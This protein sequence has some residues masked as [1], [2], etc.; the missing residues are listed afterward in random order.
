MKQILSVSVQNLVGFVLRSGDLAGGAFIS[1]RM[2]DGVRG[3]RELQALRSSEHEAA[4]GPGEEPSATY[5]AEVPLSAR[6]EY[7]YFTLEVTGRADGV[8]TGPD[9]S[10]T[11]EEIKTVS[12]NPAEIEGEGN[13]LHWAQAMC[14]AAML[15]QNGE[16]PEITIRLTYYGRG[17]RGVRSFHRTHGADELSRFFADLSDRY[18][19]WAELL[20]LRSAER[21]ASIAALGFPF[22]TYRPGQRSFAARVY[23]TVRDGKRLFA[24]APTGIGKTAAALF[25]ALKAL[26][27]GLTARI[28]YLTAKT[29]TAA[30]VE[31]TLSLLRERGLFLTSVTLTA[32]EKLCP[33]RHD[34]DPD[35]GRTR[36]PCA[37]GL[38]RL[39]EG[40]YDRLEPAMRELM[41]E[42]T[43]FSRETILRYAERHSLCPFEFSLDVALWCDLVVCDYNYLFDP[44]ASLKR[45]FLDRGGEYTF[46]IDEAH[47]L[48]E[49]AREMFSAELEKRNVLELKRLAA[50]E[51][52]RFS[53]LLGAINSAFLEL[54]RTDADGQDGRSGASGTL[55]ETLVKA[56]RTW[57]EAYEAAPPEPAAAG[58]RL[59]EFYFRASEFLR[60]ADQF[61]ER[62]V[63]L[64][65]KTVRN[66]R[67]KLFCLDPSELLE[68]SLR[69]GRAAVFFSATLSPPGYF[70]RLLCAEDSP[71]ETDTIALPS[72][73]PRENLRIVLDP[74][75]STRYRDREAGYLKIA[76]R[77]AVFVLAR[78][79]NYLVFFPSYRYLDAVYELTRELLAPGPETGDRDDSAAPPGVSTS[80]GV[81]AQTGA[82]RT[83]VQFLRQS[84][85][86]S[87][88]ERE[89]FIGSF[90]TENRGTLVGFA[91]S[92]GVFAEG[93]DLAGER[94]S[95]AVVV[96][97]GL[98]QVSPERE[99][100]REYFDR[101]S[102]Q[103]FEFGYAYPGMNRV[104]QAAGRVIR[105]ETD[106]GAVLLIDQRFSMPFYERLFPRHW[107][108][109]PRVRT[110][111]ELDRTLAE[112]WSR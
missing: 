22:P 63:T 66:V 77:V 45:F 43:H 87:E 48:P 12:G 1:A 53:K 79:G 94:L 65:E 78:P 31:Q 40:Y 98:P 92:G 60:A 9:G 91:V 2:A 16:P 112:F 28:F 50:G 88:R 103:G 97:V 41:R 44:G 49:R 83:E 42:R 25:P 20:Y 11:V 34:P 26:G 104:L 90:G 101:V 61:D 59:L 67:V 57:T 85:G 23:R 71:V 18:A 32:K 76:E 72:P 30:V 106:R 4:A 73:F 107:H 21:N 99:T 46:L 33:V 19:D 109:V 15:S 37:P 47:N 6:R 111:D 108:P 84:P 62:Y 80:T 110:T 36:P 58:G 52:G 51:H 75:I 13:P 14:Y 29:T 3:H 54:G 69:K 8:L 10:V 5:R 102:G 38:C 74:S 105:T 68:K 93:I 70:R 56:V 24:E 95:G 35:G 96:G 82:P 89:R 81:S 64:V 17:D 7:R 39:A 27:E 86:M 55:P 100:I